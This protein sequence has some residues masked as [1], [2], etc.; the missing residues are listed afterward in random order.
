M[1]V[2]LVF[3]LFVLA[4]LKVEFEASLMLNYITNPHI[5]FSTQKMY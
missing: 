5:L 2:D 3:V 4:G 1:G